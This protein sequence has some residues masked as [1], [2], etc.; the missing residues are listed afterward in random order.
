MP[1]E[2]PERYVAV[3]HAKDGSRLFCSDQHRD[4]WTSRVGYAEPFRAL[5]DAIGVAN[6]HGG[7]VLTWKEAHELAG[8]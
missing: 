7:Q 5:Y 6:R 8:T 4:E 3:L 2:F 1:A